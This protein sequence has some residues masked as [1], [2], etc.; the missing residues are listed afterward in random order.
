MEVATEVVQPS[1]TPEPAG[2]DK[3]DQIIL[4]AIDKVE[5]GGP[6]PE[7]SA[8]TETSERPRDERGRFASKTP[9]EAEPSLEEPAKAEAETAE[10]TPAAEPAQQPLDPHPRWSEA[11]KARFATLPREAQEFLLAREKATEADYTRKTQEIAEQRKSI[12]PLANE[13]TRWN[14]LFSH[15][16]TTPDQFMAE[17][18]AVATNLLSGSVEQR[19]NAIAY[20]VN[21]YQ[22]PAQVVVQAMGIPLSSGADGQASVDPHIATLSQ[23]ISQLQSELYQMREQAQLTERQR[24]EAE[25]NALAH[26]KDETGNVKF[27]HFE[28]VRQAMLQLAA[29]GRANTWEEA[30]DQAIHTEPDLRKEMVEAAVKREREAWEKQRQ[31]A[32]EKA[33]KAQPVKTTNSMVGGSV[34]AKGLDAHIEAAMTKAGFV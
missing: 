4:S 34:K 20:L 14:Q 5:G 7:P 8:E 1:D 18:A 31:E 30:Y 13:A 3:L 33:K 6:P 29:S 21:R 19:G 16:G 12:E 27:P 15:I 17:S 23:T 25:F 32:V 28:R 9:A 22:I 10:A 11:D 26:A 24:A 2:G